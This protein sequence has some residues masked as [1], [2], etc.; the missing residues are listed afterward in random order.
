MGDDFFILTKGKVRI[1]KD[2][3][4]N[5]DEEVTSTQKVLATLSDE[6]LPTF[7]E[8]G[9]L[10]DAP[11]NANVIAATDCQLYSLNM[12]DFEAFSQEHYRAAY[13]IVKNIAQVLTERLNTTD[14]NLVKLA[15]ALY[16]AVQQ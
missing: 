2:L 7:G 6:I 15:T 4:K 8:N 14:E 16:I 1:T 12:H 5:Y 11:R 9:I 3:V 10:G 13:F